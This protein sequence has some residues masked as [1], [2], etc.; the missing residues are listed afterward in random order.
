MSSCRIVAGALPSIPTGL[1]GTADNAQ[2]SLSWNA[3]S[4]AATYNV[5]RSTNNGGPYAPM[6]S[7]TTTS[8]TDTGLANGTTYYYVVSAASTNGESGNSLQIGATPTAPPV[9]LIP[10]PYTNG[11]FT[12]QF[13]AAAGVTYVIQASTNLQDWMPIFTNQSLGGQFIYTDTNASAP[14]TFYRAQQ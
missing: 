14:A 5:K 1:S 10:G 11:Q 3:S 13:Q 9:T 4:G 8:F 12:L 2:V 7:A 6:A